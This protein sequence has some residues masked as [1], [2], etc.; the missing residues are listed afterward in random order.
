MILDVDRNFVRVSFDQG[1]LETHHERNQLA[2]LFRIAADW[3][4]KYAH[5]D[6]ILHSIELRTFDDGKAQWPMLDL[7]LS[8]DQ[9]VLKDA[10][11][12]PVA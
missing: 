8:D 9:G 12:V 11:R 10:T 1:D 6:V 5:G 7:Y 4:E 3:I 2:P